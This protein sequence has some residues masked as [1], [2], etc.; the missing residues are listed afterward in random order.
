MCEKAIAQGGRQTK[1][2]EVLWIDGTRKWR[3]HLTFPLGWSMKDDI[4][5]IEKETQ[6]RTRLSAFVKRI[7]NN[8]C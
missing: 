5:T 4:G 6:S 7:G 1:R 3:I 8:P 2:D